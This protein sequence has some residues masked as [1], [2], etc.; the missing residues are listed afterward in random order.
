MASDLP[1]ALGPVPVPSYLSNAKV[2]ATYDYALAA[3][4]DDDAL[5]VEIARLNAVIAATPPAAPV[6]L[7]GI[8]LRLGVIEQSVDALVHPAVNVVTSHDLVV[9]MTGDFYQGPP[10][11][12]LWIAGTG[13]VFGSIVQPR[14]Q[15]TIVRFALQPDW[16]AADLKFTNDLYDGAPDKDRNLYVVAVTLDG[17]AV[18]LTA[19]DLTINGATRKLTAD[20]MMGGTSSLRIPLV[21]TP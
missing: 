18:P 7:S 11:W 12:E 20:G 21:A 2:K 6:D 1:P 9:T 4:A 3:K 15:Q 8:E 10:Q 5:R 17:K 19:L 14:P 13:I 16:T